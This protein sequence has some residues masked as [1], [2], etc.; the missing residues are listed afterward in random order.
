MGATNLLTLSLAQVNDHFNSIFACFISVAESKQGTET[1]YAPLKTAHVREMLFEK[2]GW[3]S[4][5]FFSSSHT[6]LL[7]S[8]RFHLRLWSSQVDMVTWFF[9]ACRLSK[10]PHSSTLDDGKHNGVFLKVT[11]V[12]VQLSLLDL[13]TLGG[14]KKGCLVQGSSLTRG[15]PLPSDVT[16]IAIAPPSGGEKWHRGGLLCLSQTLSSITFVKK[17]RNNNT[18][19]PHCDISHHTIVSV[20]TKNTGKSSWNSWNSWNRFKL[21]LTS[22]NTVTCRGNH[23]CVVLYLHVLH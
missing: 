6:A 11:C 22:P 18:K 4:R 13:N 5:G 16:T 9:R 10:R 3:S 8:A 14:R 2:W 19:I 20:P 17:S 7:I 21:L 23:V 1:H 15:E 12:C